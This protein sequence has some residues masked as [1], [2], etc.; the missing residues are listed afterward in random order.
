[1][2]TSSARIGILQP[3]T[4]PIHRVFSSVGL[5]YERNRIC[6]RH[7]PSM[8]EMTH[9]CLCIEPLPNQTTHRFMLQHGQ[10]HNWQARRSHERELQLVIGTKTSSPGT[11]PLNENP[12]IWNLPFQWGLLLQ[13]WCCRESVDWLGWITSAGSVVSVSLDSTTVSLFATASFKI[14]FNP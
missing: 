12:S 14:H 4:N 3:C 7:P 1:M 11:T 6:R 5:E 10:R 8:S 13:R 9:D 2:S